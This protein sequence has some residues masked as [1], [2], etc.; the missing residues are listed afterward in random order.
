MPIFLVDVSVMF[1]FMFIKMEINMTLE[2]WD[3]NGSNTSTFKRT[4][5]TRRPND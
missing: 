2:G 3:Y 1:T 4:A 5:F